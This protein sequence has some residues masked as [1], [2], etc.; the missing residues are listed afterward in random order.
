LLLNVKE[1]ETSD[2]ED[3]NLR[4]VM[5][6][7]V[8]SFSEKTEDF[9]AEISIDIEGSMSLNSYEPFIHDIFYH[10]I[11]NA[12]RFRSRERDLQIQIEAKGDKSE[13]LISVAD[14]GIGL[15]VERTKKKIFKM[16]QKFH[17]EIAGRGIGLYIMKSRV[18]ALFGDVSVQSEKS[19]GTTFLVRLP[20]N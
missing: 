2:Y 10:L 4:N 7:I 14:N 15:D 5:T 12:I 9:N 19:V 1:P 8:D 16:Y 6:K 3:L 17:P 11:S 18:T 13:V 20:V